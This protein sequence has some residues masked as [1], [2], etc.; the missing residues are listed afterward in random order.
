MSE[1]RFTIRA[2]L[3]PRSEEDLVARHLREVEALVLLQQKMRD[4]VVEA[5]EG[6]ERFPGSLSDSE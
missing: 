3:D 2:G 1:R 4:A 6:P 5:A